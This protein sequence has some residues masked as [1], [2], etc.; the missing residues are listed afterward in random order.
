MNIMGAE[1]TGASGG[2]NS[3]SAHREPLDVDQMV[4]KAQE[5]ENTTES[6]QVVVSKS[7]SFGLKDFSSV[8]SRVAET[9]SAG[10]EAIDVARPSRASAACLGDV[11]TGL[12]GVFSR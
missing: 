9:F 1:A 4:D 12:R 10:E 8:A 5:G 11:P 7:L 3:G 2:Y 6:S